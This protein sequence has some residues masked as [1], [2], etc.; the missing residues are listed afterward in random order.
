MSVLNFL[1]FKFFLFMID[2]KLQDYTK[3]KKD[4]QKTIHELLIRQVIKPNFDHRYMISLIYLCSDALY[5]KISNLK[6]KL[7]K[8][9][10]K[11]LKRFGTC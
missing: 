8:E 2:I 6:K 4:K 10:K 11:T 3:S 9:N 1:F 7:K 5:I